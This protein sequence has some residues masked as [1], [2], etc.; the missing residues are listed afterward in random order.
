MARKRYGMPA[1]MCAIVNSQRLREARSKN[2]KQTDDNSQAHGCNGRRFAVGQ[3]S[4]CN[5]LICHF[6]S[7]FLRLT[8]RTMSGPCRQRISW[9]GVIGCKR[10]PS[11]TSLVAI[12]AASSLTVA[13]AAPDYSPKSVTVRKQFSSFRS[14]SLDSYPPVIQIHTPPVIFE[15]KNPTHRFHRLCRALLPTFF[16]TAMLPLC[17]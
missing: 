16:K 10:L 13:G 3:V 7:P 6:N 17:L 5:V 2:K 14:T 4:C 8:R 11:E 12:A 15:S 1:V 9:L